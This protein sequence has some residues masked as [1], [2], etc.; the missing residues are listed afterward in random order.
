MRLQSVCGGKTISV[1]EKLIV[2]LLALGPIL[3]HYKG[4][5]VNAAVTMLLVLLPFVAVKLLHKGSVPL[6]RLTLV[7]PLMLL[8]V[9]E[10]V[11]HGT[12]VMETGQ[13]FVFIL[14][15][16]AVAAGCLNTKYFVRAITAVAIIASVAIIVQYICY[17][18][19]GF[20][21]QLAPTSLLSQQ[22]QQWVLLAQTGRV[23]VTGKPISFYRPSAFFLEPSHMF[24]YMFTPLLITLLS[25]NFGKREFR[26][27][28]LITV[29]MIFST[30]GMGILTAAG[31]WL[32]FLAKNGGK[33]TRL[34]LR[35]L[36][37]PRSVLILLALLVVVVCLMI[38]VPFFRNSVMRI[39]SSGSDYKN[40]VS[41]R[42]TS[43][44][45]VLQGMTG[46]QLLFGVADNTKAVAVN[47]TG[48][49]EEMYKYGIVGTLVSY[50]FYVQG[51]FRLKNQFFWVS[52]I[53]I[54]MSFFTQHS[55]SSFFMLYCAFTFTEGF[56]RQQEA[57]ESGSIEI[58]HPSR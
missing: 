7:L 3:Q 33:N 58:S 45:G 22:G 11:A 4:L 17:Y 54:V 31:A 42:V 5:F 16:L 53:V 8:F 20:H 9:Y 27:A 35:K 48:F 56:R 40:A 21:L 36:L 46:K 34:D 12:T 30:S 10:V 51:L 15:F 13:A 55:H 26:I 29:G 50:L 24:I 19:L 28:A 47:L 6:R 32:L 39:F 18:L 23:S 44:I 41:G 2:I 37:R 1:W 52:L 14:Y 43:G 38:W 25:P 57:A 49:S